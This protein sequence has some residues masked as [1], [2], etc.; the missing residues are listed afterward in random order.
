M[1]PSAL[2]LGDSQTQLGFSE[3][4]WVSLLSNAF[5][6]KCDVINRGFSGYNTRMLLAVLPDVLSQ[7]DVKTVKVVCL[8]IGS[9]DASFPDTGSEQA[10]PLEEFG[11]NLLKIISLLLNKGFKKEA[12][13]IISPPPI[14]PEKWMRHRNMGP[15]PK[16]ENYKDNELT[17]KY[18]EECKTVAARV[19][20]TF[21][22][23]FAAMMKLSNL[24]AALNDGLHL[25]KEGHS[26]LFNL[27]CPVFKEK[28]QHSGESLL[29][30][31]WRDLSNKSAFDGTDSYNKWKK[32]NA[33]KM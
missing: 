13:V 24:D 5:I 19:S 11:E 25:D 20:I 18:A 28:L 6:R 30:P 12:I 27:L 31:E 16:C 7:I 10:V 15:G 32:S 1:W 14:I 17:K 22:D 21:V 9:N 2:L 33:D 8:M 29:Y 4:G 26:T 3:G 23:L